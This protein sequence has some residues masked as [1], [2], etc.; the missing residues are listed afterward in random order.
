M[1][2]QQHSPKGEEQLGAHF[3]LEQ[4][5]AACTRTWGQ[6]GYRGPWRTGRWRGRGVGWGRGAWGAGNAG[7]HN[8]EQLRAVPVA[9]LQQQECGEH[10]VVFTPTAL[11]LCSC[12]ESAIQSCQ[13]SCTHALHPA[14]SC[15]HVLVPTPNTCLTHVWH[16]Q[17]SFTGP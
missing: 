11:M 12:A 6:R 7:V 17:P 3:L 8:M 1:W 10:R 16:R 14:P 9:I 2:A 13:T 5:A 15:V 4:S